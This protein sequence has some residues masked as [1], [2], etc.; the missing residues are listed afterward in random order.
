MIYSH[1]ADKSLRRTGIT[2]SYGESSQS[3]ETIRVI[4]VYDTWPKKMVPLLQNLD[5][6]AGLLILIGGHA[7][8]PSAFLNPEWVEKVLLRDIGLTIKVNGQRWVY[9]PELR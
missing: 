7:A 4:A 8:A 9:Y 6:I 1:I 5:S 2:A 3:Q